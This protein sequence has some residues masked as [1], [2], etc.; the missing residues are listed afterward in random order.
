MISL[1]P[2]VFLFS[3]INISFTITKASPPDNLV[4]SIGFLDAF[5]D[6]LETPASHSHYLLLLLYHLTSR[7][8]SIMVSQDYVLLFTA[9]QMSIKIV[10][11]LKTIEQETVGI[12]N[13]SVTYFESH[14]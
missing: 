8:P 4:T 14:F 13:T 5:L 3:A 9:S 6:V 11:K 12:F 1:Y 2:F 10:G 7:L